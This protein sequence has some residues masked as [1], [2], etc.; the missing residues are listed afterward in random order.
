MF[1]PFIWREAT[2]RSDGTLFFYPASSGPDS[3]SPD[4]EFSD[5][6]ARPRPHKKRSPEVNEL[7]LFPEEA[8]HAVR[9][10]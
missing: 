5:T 2:G 7:E 3:P 8:R 10:A 6:S 4:S 1:I 9:I